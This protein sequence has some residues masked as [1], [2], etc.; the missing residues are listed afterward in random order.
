MNL[1]K[2]KVER[3][4]IS[5]SSINFY[6]DYGNLENLRV[7]GAR[8]NHGITCFIDLR[9]RISIQIYNYIDETM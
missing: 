5:D 8:A 4:E 3:I 2:V 9:F 6:F 1:V 7:K